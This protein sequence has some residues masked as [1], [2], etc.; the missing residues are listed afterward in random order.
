MKLIVGLGN[1]GNKYDNTWHNVGFAVVEKL[2]QDWQFPSLKKSWR[3]KA[4]I[5][6]GSF[7]GEKIILAEPQTFMNQSGAAVK[8][9]AS[10]YKIPAEE[11]IVI[12]DDL[13]LV[14]GKMRFASDS[15]AGGH[16]GIKSIIET[17]GDK[18]FTRLKIGIRTDKLEKIDAADYVLMKWDHKAEEMLSS[19]AA[20]ITDYLTLGPAKAMNKWN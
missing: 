5:S 13:D 14:L 6:S 1:P 15:S 3:F 7:N 10:Y 4:L 20:A 16:N 17:L 19:N 8:A 11:I 9:V 12:H 2:R 18:K